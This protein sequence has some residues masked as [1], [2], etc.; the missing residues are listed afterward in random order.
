LAPAIPIEGAVFIEAVPLPQQITISGLGPAT[1]LRAR[2]TFQNSTSST[3]N[4]DPSRQHAV[5][6]SNGAELPRINETLIPVSIAPQ[7]TQT[8]T[9]DFA[10]PG[11]WEGNV[12]EENLQVAFT[13]NA[14][15]PEGSAAG[16]AVFRL[17]RSGPLRDSDLG[18]SL[19]RLYYNPDWQGAIPFRPRVVSV[20][21]LERVR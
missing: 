15:A 2:I 8:L 17:V 5:L 9:Y 7:S 12:K 21:R 19:G 3:W 4:V 14:D 20:L 10:L 13:G 16:R 1:G 18:E 6:V 11:R